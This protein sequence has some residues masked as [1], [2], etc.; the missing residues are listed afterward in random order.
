[1]ARAKTKIE[2]VEDANKQYEVLINLIESITYEQQISIFVF[3][4]D[5]KQAHWKRDN[6]IRD[7]LIHL[8]EWH[9]LLINWVNS[10]QNGISAN[11]LPANYNWFNYGQMNVEFFLKHQTTPYDIALNL[12]KDSHK[13]VMGLIDTF[14]SE[15]LFEKNQFTWTKTTTLGSYCVSA[16]ASHYV[17]AS[18]KIKKH[19][20]TII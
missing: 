11:F 8:Y 1:M 12:F 5:E 13:E 10:N 15:Q 17:W 4:R 7:V 6:N 9:Q 16:S 19:I 3:N 2:L 20:K 18:N 14:S